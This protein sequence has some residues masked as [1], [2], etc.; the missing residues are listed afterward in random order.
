MAD[1]SRARRSMETADL[2]ERLKALYDLEDARDIPDEETKAALKEAVVHLGS[3]HAQV[4]AERA[5][6][7]TVMDQSQGYK[8]LL[9]TASED[10]DFKR[11]AS[12]IRLMDT[13]PPRLRVAVNTFQRAM[14]EAGHLSGPEGRKINDL[15]Q[16][17]LQHDLAGVMGMSM[18]YNIRAAVAALHGLPTPESKTE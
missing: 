18:S 10:P 6:V 2:I 15:I 5:M 9:L 1:F 12:Q 14:D 17:H 8:T 16:G 4:E 7:K 3:L 11:A 13:Y